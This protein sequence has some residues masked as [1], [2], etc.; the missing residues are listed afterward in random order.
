MIGNS[1]KGESWMF[2][3]LYFEI[4]GKDVDIL[5]N[6]GLSCAMLV[7]SILY[8]SK[9]ISDIH[10]TVVGTEKDMI[11][12]GWQEIKDLRLG[13]VLVWEKKAGH[14]GK[15]HSHIGFY[16][17]NNEAISNDSR[18]TG[19]PRKHHYTYN[20]TRK[21]EKIYWHPELND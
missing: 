13:A 1:V 12:G 9:L 3:N 19:F 8:L 14:S 17:G 20:E 18:G 10:T 21:I 5:G 2:K 6:G 11:S 15:M 16:M 4:D 7:S